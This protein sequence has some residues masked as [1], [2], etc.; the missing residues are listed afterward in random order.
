M[1]SG[2][3]VSRP[4]DSGGLDGRV[5]VGTAEGLRDKYIE[6][7][8]G[9][10]RIRR[11]SHQESRRANL[12]GDIVAADRTHVPVEADEVELAWRDQGLGAIGYGRD[13]ASETLEHRAEQAAIDRV[14]VRN[15]NVEL[16]THF[17]PP[18]SRKTPRWMIA[19]NDCSLQFRFLT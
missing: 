18:S 13:D 12:R 17:E 15:E 3:T 8:W 6:V 5:D 4:P 16:M 14:I 10:E 1:P 9:A 19:L 11:A 2:S 7:R